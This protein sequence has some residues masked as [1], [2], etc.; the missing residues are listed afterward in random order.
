MSPIKD[1]Q[2]LWEKR[3]M[4]DQ[5]KLSRD[6]EDISAPPTEGVPGQVGWPG[7]GEKPPTEGQKIALKRSKRPVPDD[8]DWVDE[9]FKKK[10]EDLQAQMEALDE[11]EKVAKEKAEEEKRLAEETKAAAEEQEQNPPTSGQ[12]T[13]IPPTKTRTP[14]TSTPKTSGPGYA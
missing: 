1:Y 10:R 13:R 3:A 7:G 8:W 12:T 14:P 9:S 11:E 2:S 6:P 4:A 5:Q